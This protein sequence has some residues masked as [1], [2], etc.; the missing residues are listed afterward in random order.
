MENHKTNY[1]TYTIV[2]IIALFCL[3]FNGFAQYPSEINKLLKEVKEA[4]FGD[5][6]TLF[7]IGDQTI[8][9]TAQ[10]KYK[11]AEAEVNIYYANYFY[12]TRN[13]DRAKFYF[14]KAKLKAQTFSNK[15]IET[16]ANIRFI[17]IDYELGINEG[18]RTRLS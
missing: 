13:I 14:D 18:S 8:H 9:K 15:H 11:G 16:L 7:K 1:K 4:S 10:T 5:S 12:Y 3:S 17:F 2:L 6:A